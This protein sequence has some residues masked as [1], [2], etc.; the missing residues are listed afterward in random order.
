MTT[1]RIPSVDGGIQPTIIDAAG[2]L[3]YGASNDTPAR[4][5]IGTAKQVLTVNSG[6][7]APEWGT[8]PT[9]D[10]V[11]TAGDLIYGTAAD[12]VTRLAIGTAGQVLTV[13]SGATAPQWA[14]PATA[15][16][17]TVIATGN[18]T[19]NTTSITSIPQ[20]YKHL[21]LVVQN[22][23]PVNDGAEL[24]V[25]P[26]GLTSNSAQQF[27]TYGENTNQSF[28][29]NLWNEWIH[30]TDNA[31]TARTNAIMHIWNYT[32]TT[33]WKIAEGLAVT[34]NPTTTS[35][36]NVTRKHWISNKTGAITQLDLYVSSGNVNT[37]TYTLYGVN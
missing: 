31:A 25:A 33:T 18:L 36:A 32:S 21:Q 5:A 15:G 10:V 22:F 28:P 26:N 37:G 24:A 7:T 23:Q 14:T 20:T 12:T 34:V 13:N 9:A 1:G 30:P 6:A 8:D 11:T 17:L 4:L 19:S 16:G 3:I 27:D 2:D 29:Q 35:N